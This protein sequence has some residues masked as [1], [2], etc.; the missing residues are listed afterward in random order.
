MWG[1]SHFT[2]QY[3]INPKAVNPL[4]DRRLNGESKDCIPITAKEIFFEERQNTA[5]AMTSNLGHAITVHN[6]SGIT[7]GY[8][9]SDLKINQS[10]DYQ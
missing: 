3:C 4:K 6:S 8:T 7:L 2:V 10:E 1:P 9:K 5:I